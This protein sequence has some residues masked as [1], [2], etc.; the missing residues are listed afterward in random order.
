M[1]LPGAIV[2]RNPHLEESAVSVYVFSFQTVE[3]ILVVG[4]WPRA[5]SKK[6][7]LVGKVELGA[8]GVYTGNHIKS[9]GVESERNIRIDSILVGQP[10]DEEEACG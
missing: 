1:R 5:G 6:P 9:T 7:G 3:R 8:I 2:I 4:I 10:V